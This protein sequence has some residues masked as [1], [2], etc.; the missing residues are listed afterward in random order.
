MVTKISAVVL[1]KN[2]EKNL[3]D[4]LESISWVDQIVV[5][6]DLSTDRTVEIAK[7]AGCHVVIHPRQSHPHQRTLGISHCSFDWILMLDADERVPPSLREEIRA[8]QPLDGKV[9][10][11]Y[12]TIRQEFLFWRKV[13]HTEWAPKYHWFRKHHIRLF[14]K[15]KCFFRMDQIVHEV[16]EGE[17]LIGRL[18]QPVHHT[19][20]N[21]DIGTRFQKEIR[22]ARREGELRFRRGFRVKWYDF[23]FRPLLGFFKSFVWL[24][25]FMDG[26]NGLVIAWCIL[27]TQVCICSHVYEKQEE[28]TGLEE[29]KREVQSLWRNS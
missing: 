7:A 21:P 5:V 27:I 2:E 12:Y 28:M 29:R 17:G 22:D 15:D 9:Y 11:G 6:D 19:N 10:T 23:I 4:C 18:L 3:P 8:L 24:R 20:T 1:T 14:R 26:V 25:G 16:A 13:Q